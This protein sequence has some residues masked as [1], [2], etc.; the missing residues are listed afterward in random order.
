L[1][2]NGIAYR[3]ASSA[4]H[5]HGSACSL[6]PTP[7]ASDGNG[8]GVLGRDRH[9][10]NLKDAVRNTDGPGPLNP[11]LAEWLMGLDIGHTDCD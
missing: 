2:R 10:W 9:Y 11:A 6:W 5:T 8:G 4:P 1:T 7:R 3:R